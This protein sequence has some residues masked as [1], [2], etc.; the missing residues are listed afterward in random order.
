RPKEIN[1]E[2]SV[3]VFVNGSYCPHCVSQIVALDRK[4]AG[5]GMN[6]S[7]I[8]AS[9]EDD[10]ARFPTVW[11]DL[12]ADPELKLFKRHGAFDGEA[13]HA[14]IVRDRRGQEV[15]RKV[16]DAPFADV[17]AVLTALRLADPMF[18]IAVANTDT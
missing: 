15:F 9:T 8:T 5:R 10:L 12:V 2:P 14:T 13:K 4:L 17:E 7:V 3:L 11:F 16:G 18:A 6:V 1:G